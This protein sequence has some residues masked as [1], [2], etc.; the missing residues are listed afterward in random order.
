MRLHLKGLGWFW[1]DVAGSGRNP[2]KQGFIGSISVS[3]PQEKKSPSSS[4]QDDNSYE[5]IVFLPIILLFLWDMR[6]GLLAN[7]FRLEETKLI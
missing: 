6:K 3:K 7:G 5:I 1:V 2:Q 4:I